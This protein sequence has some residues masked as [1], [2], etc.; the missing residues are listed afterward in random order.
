MTNRYRQLFSLPS[1]IQP[2]TALSSTSHLPSCPTLLMT[3]LS[4]PLRRRSRAS[5]SYPSIA[6]ENNLSNRINVN[7]DSL[8]TKAPPSEPWT[9][10]RMTAATGP[11]HLVPPDLPGGT[12]LESTTPTLAHSIPPLGPLLTLVLLAAAIEALVNATT[13]PHGP[14]P[15]TS[16]MP[17]P[18][19]RHET[20]MAMSSAFA[21]IITTSHINLALNTNGQHAITIT[22]AHSQKPVWPDTAPETTSTKRESHR[23]LITCCTT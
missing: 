2:S 14:A 4:I 16:I 20:D 5:S 23:H 9:E 8:A 7:N 15:G 13:L 19:H 6:W 22:G 3:P 1:P 18:Q 11:Y 12:T 21:I 17:L 10:L